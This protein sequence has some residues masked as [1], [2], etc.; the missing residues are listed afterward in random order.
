MSTRFHFNE[1]VAVLARVVL[2]NEPPCG[3]GGVRHNDLDRSPAFFGYLQSLGLSS[4]G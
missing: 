2:L 1:P 3:L 4:L